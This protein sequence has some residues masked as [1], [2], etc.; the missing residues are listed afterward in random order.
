MYRLYTL[1]TFLMVW[2]E[3]LEGM[4][5]VVA[6]LRWLLSLAFAKILTCR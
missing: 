5:V 4:S 3:D 1:F 2:G 6:H